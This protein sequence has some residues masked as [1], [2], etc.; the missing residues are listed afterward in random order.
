MREASSTRIAG[1]TP[2]SRY[3]GWPLTRTLAWGLSPGVAGG[4]SRSCTAGTSGS[5]WRCLASHSPSTLDTS[6]GKVAREGEWRDWCQV[7][8][9]ILIGK[10]N[11]ESVHV[12]TL[13]TANFIW[14]LCRQQSPFQNRLM[15]SFFLSI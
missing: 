2:P 3:P 6:Y 4:R 15:S 9:F 1:P 8:R 5:G 14:Y 10:L 13:K 11:Q 7:R 12:R